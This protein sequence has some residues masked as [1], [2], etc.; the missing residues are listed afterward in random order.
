[1][2][3]I[4]KDL[5]IGDEVKAGLIGDENT[6]NRILK[7]V[8]SYEKGEW[9]NAMDYARKIEVDISKIPEMYLESI[10]WADHI[11]NN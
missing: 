8:I 5:N 2:E 11:N 4:I 10:E 6:L 1:M 3:S 7:L 9:E